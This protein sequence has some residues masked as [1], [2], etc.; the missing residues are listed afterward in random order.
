[1]RF[2]YKWE[3]CRNNYL[4]TFT[5]Y[6]DQNMK[7]YHK[8]NSIALPRASLRRFCRRW[9]YIKQ[10]NCILLAGK[11]ISVY[12]PVL[13]FILYFSGE[14]ETIQ[15]VGIFTASSEDNHMVIYYLAA[16]LDVFKEEGLLL[17]NYCSYDKII[18]LFTIFQ[19]F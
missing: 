14:S 2:C 16:F 11:W 13:H 4:C 1:M 6:L 8:A 7:S 19:L 9:S 18:R 12:N 10:S 17:S 15:V 3:S 5:L